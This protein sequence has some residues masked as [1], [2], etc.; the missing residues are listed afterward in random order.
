MAISIAYI[1]KG[2]TSEQKKILI[3]R[4]KEACMKALG[5]GFKHSYI[6]LQEIDPDCM[7]ETAI[8]MKS[9]IVFTTNDKTLEAKNELCRKFDEACAEA[10]GENKGRTIVIFKEHDGNNAGSNGYLRPFAPKKKP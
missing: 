3:Q 7:D 8:D 9:L 4:T 10:F 2:A 5:L 6:Y 1:P